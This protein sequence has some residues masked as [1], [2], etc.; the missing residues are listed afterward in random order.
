MLLVIL[1]SFGAFPNNSTDQKLGLGQVFVRAGYYSL[2]SLFTS[3]PVWGHLVHI[4]DFWQ[5]CIS[6]TAHC[7]ANHSDIWDSGTPVT[8][9]WC[10][11]DLVVFKYLNAQNALLATQF[12][13]SHGIV[14]RQ[15]GSISIG[16][17]NDK[18]DSRVAKNL[19]EVIIYR[20]FNVYKPC[21]G[22]YIDLPQVNTSVAL[23]RSC[24]T[25]IYVQPILSI[26]GYPRN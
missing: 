6:K 2:F 5:L 3:R 19:F 22:I 14:F 8:H 11:F 18:T 26:G 7:G 17:G 13:C 24:A 10:T 15:E 9:I 16:N 4:S 25:G 1:T 12:L 23:Y 20:D 21:H